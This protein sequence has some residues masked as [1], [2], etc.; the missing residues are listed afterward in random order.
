MHVALGPYFHDNSTATL[1]D[2]VDYFNSDDYNQS[3]DGRELPIQRGLSGGAAQCFWAID[4]TAPAGV[5][6]RRLHSPEDYGGRK[7]T[8]IYAP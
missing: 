4:L 8:G 1:E 5:E 7:F 2:V 6:R 3:T